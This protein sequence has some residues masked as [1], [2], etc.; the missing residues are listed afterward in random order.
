METIKEWLTLG[1]GAQDILD[2]G[3]LFNALRSFLEN[4]SDHV[5]YE[6]KNFQDPNVQYVWAN[7]TD[8]RSSLHSSFITQTMRPPTSRGHPIPRGSL[9]GNPGRTRNLSMRD[10]PDIDRIDAEDFVDN[11]DG[12]ACAAFSNVT[13]EVR[14]CT[15]KFSP[16]Y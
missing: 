11:L 3:Q 8:T 6:S 7:L 16:D 15:Y 2:D 5:V 4:S 1:G 12:M 9:N 13:E 10:P 14:P